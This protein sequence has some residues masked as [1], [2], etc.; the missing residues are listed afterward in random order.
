MTKPAV[1][2]YK[3][4]TPEAEALHNE[5]VAEMRARAIR[6]RQIIER[7]AGVTDETV[8]LEFGA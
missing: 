5:Q 8:A 1:Y 7:A 4:A 3:F 2:E 6:R